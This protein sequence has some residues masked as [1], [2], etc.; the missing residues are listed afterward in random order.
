M[1]QW[2]KF[3][4]QPKIQTT[5][6]ARQLCRTRFENIIHM[7]DSIVKLL[8]RRDTSNQRCGIVKPHCPGHPFPAIRL[9]LASQPA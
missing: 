5:K 7:S 6:R 9:P 3:M 2:H 1:A 4:A 8:H